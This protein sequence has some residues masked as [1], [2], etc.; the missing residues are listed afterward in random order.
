MPRENDASLAGLLRQ[1]RLLT[2]TGP[3]GVGKSRLARHLARSA[4]ADLF[5]D[6]V[7]HV[8][9]SEAHDPRAVPLHVFAAFGRTL[10]AAC[11]R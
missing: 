2:L 10:R 8:D 11:K 7:V 6:G 5:A 9:L 4:T 3:A 1:T